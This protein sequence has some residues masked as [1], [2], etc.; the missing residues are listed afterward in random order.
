MPANQAT[1][2]GLEYG[3]TVNGKMYLSVHHHR[4]SGS[5]QHKNVWAIDISRD[6]EYEIFCSSDDNDWHD[7]K[8]NYWGVLDQGQTI[9]GGRGERI[10]KFPCTTN[11]TDFWH[12]YPVSPKDKGIGDT[13]PDLLIEKWIE[14]AIIKKEFGRKIQKLKI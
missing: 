14:Q 2:A 10:C 6:L 9:L 5:V 8:S 1:I 3:P 13:P 12:G 7:T 11:D 4:G